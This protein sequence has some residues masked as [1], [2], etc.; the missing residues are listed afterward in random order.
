MLSGIGPRA[1][2]Q[3]L[4]LKVVQDLKVGYNYEDHLS[5][6][7]TFF[8]Y[9]DPLRQES[10]NALQDL[11]SLYNYLTKRTAELGNQDGRDSMLF[12]DTTKNTP[13]F[14]NLQ[15]VFIILKAQSSAVSGFFRAMKPEIVRI[16]M[17]VQSDYLVLPLLI[18]LR[19]TIHGRLYLKSVNPF[20]TVG[21]DMDYPKDLNRQ[22]QRVQQILAGIELLEK[23]SE[24]ESYRSRNMK[25]QKVHIDSCQSSVECII[26]H[27]TGTS[28]HPVGTCKMGP[29]NDPL[30]VVD[31]TLKVH[32]IKNL[33]VA[34]GSIM[35]MV[36]SGNTNIPC[37]MIG[38]KAADMIK[39]E[40]LK[41][42]VK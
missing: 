42:N 24:T 39:R 18:P 36:I 28:H 40:W 7:G 32:G 25:L 2:L 16:L 22:D 13:D 15:V 23:F 35:P 31:N 30:A 26:R 33:R 37:I 17:N 21:I 11:D 14:P 9:E 20:V 34:D 19:P 12:Y 6:E 29:R 1:H 38:E 27:M 10:S 8:T 3:E 4:G 5:F 41:Y